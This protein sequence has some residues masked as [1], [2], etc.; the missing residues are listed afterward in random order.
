MEP[1]WTSK[2]WGNGNRESPF[3]SGQEDVTDQD[4]VAF[5]SLLSSVTCSHCLIPL[6]NPS[7]PITISHIKE[8]QATNERLAE[9][10]QHADRWVNSSSLM[11]F[12][13]LRDAIHM[14]RGQPA[15]SAFKV[16]CA[17]KPRTDRLCLGG[18]FSTGASTEDRKA[19]ASGLTLEP[20]SSP[21]RGPV[22]LLLQMSP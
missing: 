17:A 5:K 13:L 14:P 7:S 20:S 3:C 8:S 1:F 2:F 11:G 12:L 22:T 15:E 16:K 4:R 21:L 9:S 10:Q 19:Q 18:G 6:S